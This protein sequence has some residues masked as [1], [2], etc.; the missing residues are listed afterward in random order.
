LNYL[1]ILGPKGI[2]TPDA[3]FKVSSANHYTIGPHFLFFI[4]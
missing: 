2:R 4:T 3:R 1:L